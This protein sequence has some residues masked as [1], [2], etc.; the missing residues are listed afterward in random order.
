MRYRHRVPI[1]VWLHSTFYTINRPC[2]G[3]LLARARI[4]AG[5]NEGSARRTAALITA[6]RRS[7]HHGLLCAGVEEAYGRS[8]LESALRWF[9]DDRIEGIKIA[10]FWKLPGASASTTFRRETSPCLAHRDARP[11]DKL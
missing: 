2:S 10:R 9:C 8:P 4:A 6:R 5:D 3:R 11:E 7:R 1:D